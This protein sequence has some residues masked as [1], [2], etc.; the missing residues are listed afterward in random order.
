MGKQTKISEIKYK[1]EENNKIVMKNVLDLE[2]KYFDILWSIFSS[3]NFKN[4]L[5]EIE[6]DIQKNYKNLK[7]VWNIKNKL[8]IP[9]ERL[10]RHYVYTKLHKQIVRIYPSPV[11]SDIA[12]ITED[13]VVNIDIKTIDING[14]KTDIDYLQFENNQSSFV[15]DNL[16]KITG[17]NNSGVKVE[18]FLPKEISN[19]HGMKLPLLTFFLTIIY[20]DDQKS[21]NI[22]RDEKYGTIYLKN[23]PNGLISMLFNNDIVSNFKTY[24]YLSEKDGENFKPIFL[25]DD[26]NQIE[27]KIN[28]FVKQ[29]K[30]YKKIKGR[31]R[32]GVFNENQIHPKSKE[33]GV[34][35]FEV[36]RKE[37]N[38]WVFMLEAVDKGHTIRVRNDILTIRFDSNNKMWEGLKKITL[39][40]TT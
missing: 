10:G 33:K 18:C 25:T 23:L 11:S 4:D 8:K 39:K 19:K 40:K 22:C 38:R 34:S 7:N 6:N 32:F 36:S 14:N 29:N 28:E 2:K 13:A 27:L 16:D 1:I 35:W 20:N 24:D 21:F 15:N 30:D 12:F 37:G 26:K 5:V 3:D 31:S 17:I 9:A